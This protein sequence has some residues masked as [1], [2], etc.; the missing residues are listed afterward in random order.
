MSSP[1]DQDPTVPSP[2]GKEDR[3]VM[4]PGA[5][6]AAPGT[7][8]S[9]AVQDLS[10]DKLLLGVLRITFEDRLVPA[11]GGIPLLAKLG[12]GGMG[13]VYF[14]YKI[15]LK[16]EVAVK[17]LPLHLA[18]QQPQLVE[19][20]LREAQVAARIE[21]PHLVH[22]SDVNQS[23]GLFYL[24]MEYVSGMSAGTYLKRVVQAGAPGLDEATALDI[25]VAAASGLAAAHARGVIHRDVNPDNVLLPADHSTGSFLFTSAKL[26]DLG[27][28]R[29]DDMGG[30]SLTGGDLGMGTPG[31]MAPEQARNARTAGKPA[32]VFS[33]GATLY[34]LLAARAPFRGETPT[35]TILATIQ[36]THA[37][38][39]SVRAEVSGPTAELI[40]RCLSK[41]PSSRYADASALLRALQV[42]RAALG[43]GQLRQTEAVQ[44]LIALQQA[45]EVGQAV[46]P[47]SGAGGA[48]PPGASVQAAAQTV[49]PSPVPVLTST[50]QRPR[51]SRLALLAVAAIAGL[52]AL[53]AAPRLWTALTRADAVDVGIAFGSEKAAWL[54]WAEEQFAQTPD[55]KRY[56]VKLLTMSTTE[57]QDALSKDDTRIHAWFPSSGVF[58]DEFVKA[59]QRRHPGNPIEREEH[60]ALTPFAFVMFEDRYQAFVKR[61]KRLTL[62]TLAQAFQVKN[63]WEGIAERPDL[64]AIH[65]CDLGSA[66]I[67]QRSGGVDAAGEPPVPE[68]PRT[69]GAGRDEQRLLVPGQ[70]VAAR[71][72]HPRNTARDDH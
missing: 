26:A 65:V 27:L 49:A 64:G 48:T 15:L 44:S 18:Q 56:A 52:A 6:Q 42:C 47:S 23:E 46:V 69:I 11:L 10:G 28:A 39:T 61:Y 50:I 30:A 7:R 71:L 13:A 21:S 9:V 3:T 41:D 5:R 19:R 16:R 59:W 43:E 58:R 53:L 68:G 67:Q 72:C 40:E 25:C 36:N 60:V 38:I 2:Q 12:Q 14:G 45:P 70:D 66:A 34:A 29:A 1:F 57:A 24:T 35:E 62:Q 17:V 63:G 8:F 31:F 4:L 55:G 37:P 33:L 32:D 51:R 22:V 20:F 54:T